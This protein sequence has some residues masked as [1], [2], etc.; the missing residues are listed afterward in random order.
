MQ[1]DAAACVLR[2]ALHGS[3]GPAPN[4]RQQLVRFWHC[5]T[6]CEHLVAASPKCLYFA[7]F[8]PWRSDH[9]RLWPCLSQ[10]RSRLL[11][12]REAQIVQLNSDD[13]SIMQERGVRRGVAAIP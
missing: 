11:V 7:H 9:I 5:V 4:E 6:Y 1:L 10:S 2:K 8:K 3:T 13:N 12:S